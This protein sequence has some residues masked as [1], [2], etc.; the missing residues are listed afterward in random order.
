MEEAKANYRIFCIRRWFQQIWRR[1]ATEAEVS[2]ILKETA[3]T[4]IHTQTEKRMEQMWFHGRFNPSWLQRAQRRLREQK[5]NG[6]S[7]APCRNEYVTSEKAD[8]SNPDGGAPA[9][10]ADAVDGKA[11]DG[12]LE[13]S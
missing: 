1:E 5:E 10:V 13:V 8:G 3:S 4:N 11:A 2:T 12:Q 9:P 6:G 7:G